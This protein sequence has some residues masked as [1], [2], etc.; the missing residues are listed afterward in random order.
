MEFRFPHPLENIVDAIKAAADPGNPEDGGLAMQLLNENNH[1]LEDQLGEQVLTTVKDT[2]TGS[3]TG[4]SSSFDMVTT[5]PSEGLW[6]LSVVAY[7]DGATDDDPPKVAYAYMDVAGD[8]GLVSIGNPILLMPRASDS[9]NTIQARWGVT[10][11]YNADTELDITTTLSNGN[12]LTYPVS[13]R[14][15]FTSS[16]KLWGVRLGPV[17]PGLG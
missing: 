7:I 8:V 3:L 15:W 13:W 5:L 9:T 1:A 4:T 6:V 2:Q 14:P 17:S 11:L 12:T 16:L 10:V